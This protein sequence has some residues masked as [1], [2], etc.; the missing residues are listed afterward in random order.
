MARNLNLKEVTPQSQKEHVKEI[1]T[2]LN[3]IGDKESYTLN[4]GE[5]NLV[6]RALSCHMF[7]IELDLRRQ[8]DERSSENK[9]TENDRTES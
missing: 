3:N 6:V 2:L 9:T 1:K 7:V 5:L 4:E 8:K